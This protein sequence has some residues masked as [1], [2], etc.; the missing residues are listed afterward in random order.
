MVGGSGE[1]LGNPRWG[2][3]CCLGRCRDKMRRREHEFLRALQE[4]DDTTL[5]N[6][7]EDRLVQLK[8]HRDKNAER[9]HERRENKIETEGFEAAQMKESVQN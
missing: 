9:E 5:A 6:D 2:H 4:N 3:F 1:L 8:E 7:Q